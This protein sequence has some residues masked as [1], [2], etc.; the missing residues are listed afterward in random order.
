MAYGPLV[1]CITVVFQTTILCT[2]V[3]T[4]THTNSLSDQCYT[5][6]VSIQPSNSRKIVSEGSYRI[7]LFNLYSH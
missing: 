4:H 1:I 2:H 6:F 3:H 7:H 5:K